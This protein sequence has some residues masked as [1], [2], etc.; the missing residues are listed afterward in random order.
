MDRSTLVVL[1]FE[2]RTW[3]KFAST[4]EFMRQ[5]TRCFC[6]RQCTYAIFLIKGSVQEVSRLSTF[7]RHGLGY[8]M[9]ACGSLRGNILPCASVIVPACQYFKALG[10]AV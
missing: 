10:D 1:P 9:S 6:M 4:K 7:F 5:E 3:N 8:R 2:K